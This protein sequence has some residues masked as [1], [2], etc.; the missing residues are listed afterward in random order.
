MRC[1][2]R[3]AVGYF[4]A[5]RSSVERFSAC[6]MR[7]ICLYCLFADISRELL[8]EEDSTNLYVCRRFHP[9][10]NSL[11]YTIKR[12]VKCPRSR[13]S[14]T[15]FWFKSCTSGHGTATYTCTLRLRFVRNTAVFNGDK[16]TTVRQ[17]CQYMSRQLWA[18]DMHRG[19]RRIALCFMS[20]QSVRWK[21]T[22]TS[23][24]E[25]QH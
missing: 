13:C 5:W 6:E 14:L 24:N 9:D 16:L 12:A 4:W 3:F 17:T 2:I 18:N 7:R 10:S 1:D 21:T 8:F 23:Y 25:F 11:L 19:L 15:N 20:I 22:H